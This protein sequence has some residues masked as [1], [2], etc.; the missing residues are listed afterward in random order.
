MRFQEWVLYETC[1][2]GLF[3]LV[4]IPW[5]KLYAPSKGKL[6]THSKGKPSLVT[7]FI[8][9]M[10]AQMYDPGIIICSNIPGQDSVF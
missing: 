9:L 7:S 5:A 3:S 8:S 4:I 10:E 6:Y 2:Y 1:I